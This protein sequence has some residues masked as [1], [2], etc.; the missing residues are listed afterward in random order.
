MNESNKYSHWLS[1][2][3]VR[4][5]LMQLQ[6]FLMKENQIRVDA[7][8]YTKCKHSMKSCYCRKCGHSYQNPI[9]FVTGNGVT[10]SE[11]NQNSDKDEDET[12]TMDSEKQETQSQLTIVSTLSILHC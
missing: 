11:A 2:Y 8:T 12:K 1:T 4:S 10:G 9:P 3:N 5:V 6:T 7:T